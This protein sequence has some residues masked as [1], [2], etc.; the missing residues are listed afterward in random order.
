M[1]ST[2]PSA[3][4]ELYRRKGL[5]GRVGFGARPAL[6]VVDLSV[7]FTDPSSPL[8]ASLDREVGAAEALL[9]EARAAEIPVHFT[10]IS[11]S[12][13]PSDGGAFMKKIPSLAVLRDGS[14]LVRI[15]PRLEP[16]EGESVWTKKGASAF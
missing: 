11:F 8:G 15:D 10:T 6:L 4:L 3:T 5:A 9:D 13:H 12:A 1:T 16:R 14:P 7:G 2:D